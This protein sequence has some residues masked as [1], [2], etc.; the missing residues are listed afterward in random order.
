[1]LNQSI[2]NHP[3][4]YRFAVPRGYCEKDI[5]QYVGMPDT[6]PGEHHD[7]FTDE[8]LK[9][10]WAHRE[11]RVV[12]MILIMCYSGFRIGAWKSMRTELKEGYFQGGIKTAC[13]KNRIVPIHSAIRP[14]VEELLREQGV[15]EETDGGGPQVDADTV[16]RLLQKFYLC[17]VSVSWFR[18]LMKR[19]LTE[20]GIDRPGMSHS[21]HSCR[22]T[23]SRLCES[24]GVRE[25]D[26]KRMMGHSFGDDI[27]NGVYGHRT[28]EELRAEIEKIV[29][30]KESNAEISGHAGKAEHPDKVPS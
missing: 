4:L 7:P 28:V 27:T 30:F 1:M 5:A 29:S 8:E 2:E 6:E 20:L 15:G 18:K 16:S 24:Y 26:R 17:G 23:F 12:R 11:D 13:G 22:H 19:K 3:G 14:L 10:L 21:P 9:T 25:A